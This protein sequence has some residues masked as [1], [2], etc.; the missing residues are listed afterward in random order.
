MRL[1]GQKYS[2]SLDEVPYLNFLT[3]ND[4]KVQK[5]CLKFSYWTENWWLVSCKYLFS[6]VIIFCSVS[7]NFKIWLIPNTKTRL[8]W[9]GE[10]CCWLK[11]VQIPLGKCC[12]WSRTYNVIGQIGGTVRT[13]GYW[14][15]YLWWKEVE[16]STSLAIR[17]RE[18]SHCTASH[19]KKI[20][21][22]W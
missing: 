2:W 21:C 1:S 8:S 20:E 3:W 14:R 11:F 12:P 13:A 6:F 9:S 22:P 7:Y 19:I 18:L 5:S 17:S 10:P 15:W 4:L 16:F